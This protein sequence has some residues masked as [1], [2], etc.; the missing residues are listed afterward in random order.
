MNAQAWLAGVGGA[1]EGAA[2]GYSWQKEYDQKE[3]GLDIREQIAQ[4]REEIRQKIAE[5]TEGGRNARHETPSGDTLVRTQTQRDI[6]DTT[7]AGR[8]ARWSVPS[9]NTLFT[10]A[11]RDR[12]WNTPSANTELTELGRNTRWATPSGNARLGSETTRRGQ[13]IGASTARRGQ[14]LTFSLGTSGQ[15][16]T[17]RGQDVTSQDRRYATD[18]RNAAFAGLF[19][20]MPVTPVK[21]EPEEPEDIPQVA[22]VSPMGAGP[23]PIGRPPI[24][25]RAPGRTALPP[26]PPSADPMA[27]LATKVQ[28]ATQRYT[29]E[30]DPA[31]KAAIANELRQLQAQ[32]KALK[33]TRQ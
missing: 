16:V 18:R 13:D 11:G 2:K 1:L 25:T 6:A 3:R 27:Q 12:R 8:N 9:G 24:T 31:R 32:A 20:P 29:R 5:M 4:L 33:A 10:E 22:P 23:A 21:P 7:E 30:T 14:D 26:P 28:D 17:Q 19:G 15:Q